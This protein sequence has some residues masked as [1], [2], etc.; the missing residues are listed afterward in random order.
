MFNVNGGHVVCLFGNSLGHIFEET[1]W[2]PCLEIFIVVCVGGDDVDGC[3]CDYAG[4]G[5]ACACVFT[6]GAL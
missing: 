3:L 6:C 1:L 4:P 2:V 5:L